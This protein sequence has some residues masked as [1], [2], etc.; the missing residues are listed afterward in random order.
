MVKNE[1][2]VLGRYKNMIIDLEQL[3][4]QTIPLSPSDRIHIPKYDLFDMEILEDMRKRICFSLNRNVRH[5]TIN[6]IAKQFVNIPTCWQVVMSLL[7]EMTPNSSTF[8]ARKM[9]VGAKRSGS[10]HLKEFLT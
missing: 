7:L 6:V 8:D 4:L 2:A 3:H 9:H 10:T 1:T 5:F